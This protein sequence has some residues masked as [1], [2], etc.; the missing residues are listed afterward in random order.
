MLFAE[1]FTFTIGDQLLCLGHIGHALVLIETGTH[2]NG[3]ITEDVSVCAANKTDIVRFPGL[4]SLCPG[5]RALFA[6]LIKSILYNQ[7]THLISYQDSKLRSDFLY[8]L[9]TRRVCVVRPTGSLPAMSS[10]CS[11][12]IPV[13]WNKD[14]KDRVSNGQTEEN[15][16]KT[17]PSWL[18]TMC[19]YRCCCVHIVIGVVAFICQI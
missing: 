4:S 3:M 8:R 17:N 10:S 12:W 1:Q 5:I 16:L 6:R 9:Q 14:V 11:C 13:S 2:Q 15:K 7:Q 19:Y 18:Q